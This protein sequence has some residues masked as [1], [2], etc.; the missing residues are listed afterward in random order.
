MTWGR[1]KTSPPGLRYCVIC[2]NY[3]CLILRKGFP[4][5]GIQYL[6]HFSPFVLNIRNPYFPSDQKCIWP[7]KQHYFKDSLWHFGEISLV[8]AWWCS[9][10]L[11]A[12]RFW[13]GT[14]QPVTLWP[15]EWLF[16][17][18]WT[19]NLSRD[20]PHLLTNASWDQIQHPCD[21]DKDKV[22]ENE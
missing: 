16:V 13:V 9:G 15:R 1:F 6:P 7:S 8:V 3:Y 11:T 10:W 12:R 22:M 5:T 18:W 21:T 14:C 4:Y 20:V 17:L 19:G 2:M